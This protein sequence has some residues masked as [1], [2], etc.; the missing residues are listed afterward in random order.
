MALS[1]GIVGLPNVGKSTLFNALTNAR[2]AAE[3]FPFCTID[4]NVGIVKV[5]DTRMNEITKRIK[6][7]SII[8]STMG[9]TD[10][11][12]IVKGASKGE[13]LGNRF[14]ANIRETAAIVHVVRCFENDDVVH[15]DGSV[16]PI[17][18]V[19]VIDMELMLAD[20]ESVQ[21]RYTMADKNNKRDPK[22]HGLEFSVM[23]RIKDTLE[24]GIP[25]RSLSFSNEEQPI[26]N[27]LHLLSAKKILYAGNVSEDDVGNPMQNKYYALLSAYAQKE[28]SQI[29][30]ICGKIEA[31]LGELPEAERNEFLQSLGLEEDGLSRLIRAAYKLL[32]LSTYFTAGEKE[33]RAWTIPQECTAPQAAGV[34]H[35]DFERGF[36]KAEVY[37]VNDL[38]AHN[39]EAA[40]KAKG[41]LRLEGKEYRVKDGDIM[42]FRFNV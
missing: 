37:H 21:K 5:P 24:K 31:E 20:L 33:V 38:I 30:P 36:I 17:R 8:P 15:V 4:P 16:D 12:G 7:Q 14:L 6:P 3:N 1:C 40:V 10:I 19:T 13:G 26:V 35:T 29:V 28:G 18:D 41:L 22:L 42:F 27:E 34:I 11:A 25:V 23:T 9:F 2:V 32:G 39:T